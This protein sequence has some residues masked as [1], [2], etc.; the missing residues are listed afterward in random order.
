ME[1]VIDSDVVL[2]AFWAK[3]ET[4]R[5]HTFMVE[6]FQEKW[7]ERTTIP[8]WKNSSFVAGKKGTYYLFAVPF[9][10]TQDFQL[11]ITL[12]V[13]DIETDIFPATLEDLQEYESFTPSDEDSQVTD[14]C[15]ITACYQQNFPKTRFVGIKY[16]EEDRVNGMFGYQW[17]Q[18]FESGKFNVLESKIDEDFLFVYP[19]A[20]A[21]IGLMRY[22]EGEAFEYWIGMFLPEGCEVPDGYSY[23]DF[24]FEHVGICWVQGKEEFV[25]G[26]EEE[27]FEKIEEKGMELVEDPQNACWFFERYCCPRFTTPDKNGEIILDIGYFV[28]GKSE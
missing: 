11:H 7:E 25:Y 21:Y 17:G 22:K 14:N 6:F 12:S 15:R 23:V 27:C 1:P 10:A 3:L 5:K 16:G 8:L 24:E 26:M 13:N 18:W 4:D 20:K 2:L 28:K 19:D 9:T